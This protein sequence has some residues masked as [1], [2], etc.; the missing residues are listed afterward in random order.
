MTWST[1]STR[2]VKSMLAAALAGIAALTGEPGPA[3]AHSG[4]RAELY[5]ADLRL[6]PI[7]PSEWAV[8]ARLVDRDSGQPLPGF[9]VQVT[10]TSQSGARFGPAM[11]QDPDAR[12]DYSTTIAAPPGSWSITVTAKEIP[13]GAEGIPLVQTADVDLT[14]AP[15]DPAA[16]PV[17]AL[18]QAPS[19]HRGSSLP[20]GLLLVLGCLSGGVVLSVIRRRPSPGRQS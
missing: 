11:M 6:E 2:S 7:R 14:A 8:R 1:R 18:H 19:A 15:G 20:L 3:A 16:A 17:P 4:S 10:G 9:D 13:G 12:G 5:L